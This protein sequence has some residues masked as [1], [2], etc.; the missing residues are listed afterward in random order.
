MKLNQI[1]RL[2][3]GTLLL[4]CLCPDLRAE[5]VEIPITYNPPKDTTDRPRVP[6]REIILFHY[7]TDTKICSVE[8]PENVKSMSV[9][10]EDANGESYFNVFSAG[11]NFWHVNIAKG[12]AY[13]SCTTDKGKE[14]GAYFE[15]D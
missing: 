1:I 9:I 2:A 3:S 10:I 11:N 8:F 15:I 7:D 12:I 14:Y 13:L 5:I 6:S 4:C